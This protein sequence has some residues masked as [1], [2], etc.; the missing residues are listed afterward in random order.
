V[1][2]LDGPR[3]GAV[4]Q[5]HAYLPLKRRLREK[6]RERERERERENGECSI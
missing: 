6:E 5:I 3:A 1:K 4:I 2:G